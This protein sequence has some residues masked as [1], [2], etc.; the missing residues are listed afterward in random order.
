M[1]VSMLTTYILGSNQEQGAIRDQHVHS[2]HFILTA[3]A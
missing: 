1:L 3:S 2:H